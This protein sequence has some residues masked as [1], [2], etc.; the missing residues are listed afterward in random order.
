MRH[1]ETARELALAAVQLESGQAAG[2]RR[3]LL[4]ADG[5]VNAAQDLHI[6]GADR[7]DLRP[8]ELDRQLACLHDLPLWRL[9]VPPVPK[10]VPR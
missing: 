4:V 9:L 5:H 1:R 6:A 8:L 10:F 7:A 2:H 3:P